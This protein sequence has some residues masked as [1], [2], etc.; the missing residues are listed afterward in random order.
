MIASGIVRETNM[1]PA[2]TSKVFKPRRMAAAVLAATLLVYG[3][4]GAE[5]RQADYYQRAQDLFDESNY[6]KARIEVRNVLQIN[7]NNADG[8]YLMA[9]LE[10]K[11]RNWRG[12]F[13]N[14]N[15]ALEVDADH[16]PA[17]VKLAQLFVASGDLDNAKIQIEEALQRDPKGADAMSVKA[18]ILQREH[19]TEAAEALANQ[20]L[21]VDP[22]HVNAIGVLVGIYGD[23]EPERALALIGQGLE[24]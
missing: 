3:C 16:I 19:D 11:E 24:K 23:S 9:L 8:R 12:M 22:G 7:P 18:S 4:G 13:G 1:N 2:G 17:R 14:L 6:Q 15:A 5:E 20:A 21:E 10:E